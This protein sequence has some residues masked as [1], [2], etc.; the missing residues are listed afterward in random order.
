MFYCNDDFKGNPRVAE[1]RKAMAEEVA[2]TAS[3]YVVYLNGLDMMNGAQFL[4]GDKVH[5]N[6][7]G[8]SEIAN[9]ITARIKPYL[10]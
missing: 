8:V 10:A 7:D 2:R 5:P 6:I 3:P 1:Y 4:S 9:N